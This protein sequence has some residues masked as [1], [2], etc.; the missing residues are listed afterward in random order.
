MIDQDDDTPPA[1]PKRGIPAAVLSKLKPAVKAHFAVHGSRKDRHLLRED[2]KFSPWIGYDVG[3][4]GETG[5]KRLDRLFEEAKRDTARA[6]RRPPG[7]GA[8]L[9]ADQAKVPLHP[10]DQVLA[11]SA[12]VIGHAELQARLR[13]RLATIEDALDSCSAEGV[14]LERRDFIQLS[15]EYRAIVRDSANLARSYHADMRSAE[16]Q[17]R[18]LEAAFAALG[19]DQEKA[20]GLA[21]AFDQI[22]D[23]C[24]GLSARGEG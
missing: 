12:P 8:L 24:T 22:F 18:L 7:G 21:A 14:L 9:L 1:K 23:E 16:L 17:R 19:G 6:Q 5:D 11:A 3:K 13:R 2:P 15:Q 4:N 10:R 20:E